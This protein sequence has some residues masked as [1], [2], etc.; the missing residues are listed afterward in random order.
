MG[1]NRGSC[2]GAV[3]TGAWTWVSKLLVPLHLLELKDEEFE[4]D[5]SQIEAEDCACG[6][7][8]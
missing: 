4:F 5:W 3:Q 8:V 7:L 1:R 6:P 2:R